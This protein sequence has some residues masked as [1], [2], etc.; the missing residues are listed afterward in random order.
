M[1]KR[2][3]ISAVNFAEL[4][5]GPLELLAKNNIDYDINETGK[6]LEDAVLVAKGSQC[7]AIIAGTERLSSLISKS[8]KL[9][10]VSRIGVGLNSVPLNECKKRNIQVVYTPDAVTDSVAELTLLLILN[11]YRKANI[12]DRLAK[13]NLWERRIGLTIKDAVIGVIGMGRI[14]TAVI[15]RLVPF[16]PKSILIF[17]CIDQSE[18]IKL[19]QKKFKNIKQVNLSLL[20]ADSDVVTLH[21]PYSSETKDMIN[22]SL[23]NKMKKTVCLVNT[24]RGG[25]VNESDLFDMLSINKTASAA[26]DVFE[27]E[28]Y[29]GALLKC[30]NFTITPHIG[31]YTTTSRI[32][33]EYEAVNEI[34]RFF[35]GD[36]LINPVPEFEYLMQLKS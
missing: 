18:K 20:A 32:K 4:D 27:K 23:L 6:K 34:I 14:A 1:N 7:E 2:V 36:A 31:S 10:I 9:E 26:F 33:M 8:S 30:E 28:P 5:K 35:K 22:S 12:L 16:K 24:A 15:E 13:N 29:D 19:L 3:L 11:S 25:L 21:L 17:D